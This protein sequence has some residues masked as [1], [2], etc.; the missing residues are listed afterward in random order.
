MDG[1]ITVYMNIIKRKMKN[2]YMN[3]YSILD[4]RF[5]SGDSMV[6]SL[7]SEDPRNTRRKHPQPPAACSK[8]K[9]AANAKI[10]AHQVGDSGQ[11]VA[12]FALPAETT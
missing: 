12:S 10:D 4:I 3:I 6:N 5:E 7:N 8:P 9:I 11:Q 2:K 1:V